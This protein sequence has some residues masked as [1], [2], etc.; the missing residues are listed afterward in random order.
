MAVRMS[1]IVRVRVIVAHVKSNAQSL[2]M[3][4]RS[5]AGADAAKSISL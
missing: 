4:R 3:Q 1:V 5:L 2:K